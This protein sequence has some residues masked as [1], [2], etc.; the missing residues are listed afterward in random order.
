MQQVRAQTRAQSA[1]NLQRAGNKAMDTGMKPA[2]RKSLMV[3]PRSAHNKIKKSDP[4]YTGRSTA[5][6]VARGRS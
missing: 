6:G 3:T 5:R 2:S 1:G 4:Y